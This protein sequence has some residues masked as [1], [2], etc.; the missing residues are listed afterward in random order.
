MPSTRRSSCTLPHSASFA[1]CCVAAERRDHEVVKAVEGKRENYQTLRPER[2]EQKQ[3]P[4]FK[5]N[6]VLKSVEAKRANYT[7]L[8]PGAKAPEANGAMASSSSDGDDKGKVDFMGMDKKN[9]S[10]SESGSS[11]GFW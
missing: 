8:R 1:Y 6:P 11:S 4:T 9:A 3:D 10:G 2:K 5:Q 7:T